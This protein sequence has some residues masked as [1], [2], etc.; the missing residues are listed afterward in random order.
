MLIMG[1][2]YVYFRCTHTSGNLILCWGCCCKNRM[3]SSHAVEK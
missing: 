1:A 3:V 2:F